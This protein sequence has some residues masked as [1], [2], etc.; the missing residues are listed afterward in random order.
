MFLTVAQAREIC[1]A[2]NIPREHR[3]RF[4]DAVE[5]HVGLYH[6]LESEKSSSDVEAEFAVICKLVDKALAL[7]ARKTWR[8]G[9]FRRVLDD[10]SARLASLSDGA[11]DVLTSWGVVVVFEVPEGWPDFDPATSVVDPVAV[12]ELEDQL[13]ALREIDSV[14][15]CPVADR[16]PGQPVKYAE[17]VLHHFIAVAYERDTG[18]SA[19][20]SSVDFMATCDAITG[21]FRVDKWSPASLARL[22][23]PEQPVNNEP[24]EPTLSGS[25]HES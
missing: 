5:R 22:A 18:K 17:R 4:V 2:G 9:E 3:P 21:I 14:F 23:R 15:S 8:P 16:L 12:P 19:S 13:Y 11:Q 20:D 7:R 25:L 1:Q 24:V 6:R 10:I